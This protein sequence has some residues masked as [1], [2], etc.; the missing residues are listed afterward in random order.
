MAEK[1][2]ANITFAAFAVAMR[3]GIATLRRHFCDL[4]ALLAHLVR[5]HLQALSDAIAD[6]DPEA[7]DPA[8]ARREAYLAA[9]R[10]PGGF[11]AD[12]LL[13]VRDSPALP[14]DELISIDAARKALA[15]QLAGPN[16]DCPD[17]IL[18]MLDNPA[19]DRADMEHLIARYAPPPTPEQHKSDR[20][21]PQLP[22]PAARPAWQRPAARPSHP[23]KIPDPIS[24]P[25]WVHTAPEPMRNIA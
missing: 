21:A 25:P 19:I 14:A 12:H 1:G 6:I 8:R 20:A 24:P 18:C 17:R 9:T 10:Q 7:A 13:L 16:C 4:D 22:T 15:R 2:F 11:T 23:N 5:L 3:I